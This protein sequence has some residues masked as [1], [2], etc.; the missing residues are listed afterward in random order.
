[1][2]A[3]ANSDIALGAREREARLRDVLNAF[4]AAA[5]RE[6][7]LWVFSTPLSCAP[8][9]RE[10]PLTGEFSGLE[11]GDVDGRMREYAR[12]LTVYNGGQ[13]CIK[14]FVGKHPIFAS[15]FGQPMDCLT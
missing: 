14:A 7:E 12:V 4:E 5:L 6:F 15:N 11:S 8:S 10:W 13:S 9:E 2:R 1:M 3:F